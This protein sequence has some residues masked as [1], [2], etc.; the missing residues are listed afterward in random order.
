VPTVAID[1][2]NAQDI[3][4][5][6]QG[7]GFPW[8][9]IIT[10]D[11]RAALDWL[12][13]STPPEARVQFEP[14]ARGNGHWSL[15]P[16]FGE[17]R[18]VAGLPIAM[19]PLKKYQSATRDVRQGIFQAGTAHDAY[20]MATYLQIDYL[21]VSD[22]ERQRYPT[23]IAAFDSQPGLFAPV[24]RNTSVTIYRLASAKR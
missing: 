1:I 19:I 24:F 4:N 22:V 10:P 2:F 23:A 12:K 18:M 13:H 21:L 3:T 7:P 9:L 20:A 17:R 16:A 6:R 8:T 15:I 14:E 5:R 11:E